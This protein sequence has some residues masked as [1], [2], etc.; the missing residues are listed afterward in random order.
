MNEASVQTK[1]HCNV[2]SIVVELGQGF[3]LPGEVREFFPEE[4]SLPASSSL[5]YVSVVFPSTL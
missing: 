2:L 3:I 4:P 5:A 1:K